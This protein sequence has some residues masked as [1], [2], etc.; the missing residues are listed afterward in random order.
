MR[1][2]IAGKNSGVNNTNSWWMCSFDGKLR[3]ASEHYNLMPL[4]IKAS[5]WL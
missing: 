3:S 2:G 1:I 5:I 4:R